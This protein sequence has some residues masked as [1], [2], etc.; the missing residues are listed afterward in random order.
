MYLLRWL[1]LPAV[2]IALLSACSNQTPAE[3]TNQPPTAATSAGQAGYPVVT[4]APLG[5][6]YPAPSEATGPGYPLPTDESAPN[7]APVLTVP[8]PASNQVGVVTGKI[9]RLPPGATQGAAPFL[10]DLYLGK[11]IASTV[12]EEG[13]VE[14][15]QGSAP[16]GLIDA[17][18]VFVFK[19]VPV[20]RYGLMISTPQGAVL[21]N[22]PPEGS[23]MVID[24]TGGNTVDLGEL[25]YDLGTF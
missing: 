23:A 12:G 3:P 21:L 7:F 17:Q 2:I 9:L 18:G 1:L 8:A 22:K 14:L 6:G 20:G 16:R 11:V 19:D 5:S 25:Q 15:D 13:M 4:E 10:A 24:I